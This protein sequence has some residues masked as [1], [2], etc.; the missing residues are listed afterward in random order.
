MGLLC[1]RFF[2]FAAKQAAK[3]VVNYGELNRV[4]SS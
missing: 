1:G 3:A 4:S 2:P